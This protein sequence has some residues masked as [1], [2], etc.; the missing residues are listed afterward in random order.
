MFIT[1]LVLECCIPEFPHTGQQDKSVN[2]VLRSYTVPESFATLSQT[3]T[4]KTGIYAEHSSDKN[5]VHF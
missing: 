5:K 4:R 1:L 2:I 3:Y